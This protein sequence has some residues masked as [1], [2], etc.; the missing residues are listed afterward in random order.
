MTAFKDVGG[1]TGIKALKLDG[2]SKY[3]GT[4]ANVAGIDSTF[5]VAAL[6]SFTNYSVNAA[7]IDCND[8]TAANVMK[9]LTQLIA[10]LAAQGIVNETHNGL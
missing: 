6:F 1:L 5:N 2:A 7:V 9:A 4:S 8:A 3:V 10:T